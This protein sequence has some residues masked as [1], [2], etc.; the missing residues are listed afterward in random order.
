MRRARSTGMVV[1]LLT[2][3]T[4][5]GLMDNTAV[6]TEYGILLI[7]RSGSMTIERYT[8]KTRFEDAILAARMD[9][10]AGFPPVDQYAVMYF[11]GD[12]GIVMH[13]WFNA[14]KAVVE[15]ALLSIPAAI[16]GPRTPL[17]DAMCQ[18]SEV[19]KNMVGGRWLL[20]Y[21]DG[22]DNDSDGSEFNLCD[23]CDVLIPTGWNYDCDP[24]DDVPP[25]TDLQDCIVSELTGEAVQ[26]WRYFGNPITK[27]GAP[28][29]GSGGDQVVREWG[30]SPDSKS[31]PQVSDDFAFLKHLTVITGGEFDVL[32]DDENL[33]EDADNDGIEDFLDNCPSTHNPGQSDLDGDLIGDACDPSTCDCPFQDD[34]DEDGFITALDLSSIIDVLFAGRPDVRDPACPTWRGDDDCDG[35]STALDLS[36]KIDHLFAGGPPPC[37]PCQAPS[38]ECIGSNCDDGFLAC[39]PQANCADPL[40]FSVYEGGGVCVDADHPELQGACETFTPCPAGTGDCPPGYICVVNTCCQT[41]LCLSEAVICG[42]SKS[43]SESTQPLEVEGPTL[44]KRK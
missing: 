10:M 40:C 33:I 25:C 11:N 2:V 1:F 19:L 28:A 24:A 32:P 23:P 34:Y 41:P 22:H 18:A 38:P 16:V 8:F 36:I 35:F 13:Q 30:G 44:L 39:D 37:D 4:C 15:A 21:T 9:L 29:G 31:D 7:D 12:D 42:N 20:G 43:A 14:D 5:V 27:S 3:I 26:T 6:A 17:A